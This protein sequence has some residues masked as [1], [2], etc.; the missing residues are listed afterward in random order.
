MEK[1]K[2]SFKANVKKRTFGVKMIHILYIIIIILVS[3]LSYNTGCNVATIEFLRDQKKLS[4]KSNKKD[5][6]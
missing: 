6:T 3:I 5:E 4:N 2:K 1:N